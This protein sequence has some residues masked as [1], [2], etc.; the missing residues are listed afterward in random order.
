MDLQNAR[1]P[2]RRRPGVSASAATV[3]AVT[4]PSISCMP[5]PGL[6]LTS[7]GG[8]RGDRGR[9]RRAPP[10]PPG[11]AHGLGQVGRVLHRDAPAPRLR[12]QAD[13]PRLALLAL[14]RN[15]IRMAERAG[16]RAS[17]DSEN[18]DDWELIAKRSSATRSTCSWSRPSGS[19]TRRSAPTFCLRSPHVRACS[20]RRGPLHLRLGPRLPLTTAGSCASS[21]CCPRASPSCAPPRRRTTAWSRT[22]KRSSAPSS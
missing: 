1:S 13:D 12:R 11:P 10:G 8:S 6:G 21:S 22:S 5:S 3:H 2:S 19:T 18:R 14:M 7:A 16:V 17:I 9:R 4:D 15:Q 20:Y